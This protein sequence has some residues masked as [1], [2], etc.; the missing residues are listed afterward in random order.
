MKSI[1][2]TD[3]ALAVATIS[4]QPSPPKNDDAVQSHVYIL[5]CQGRSSHLPST[6]TSAS[7]VWLN[8]DDRQRRIASLQAS[9]PLLD[10]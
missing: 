1:D 10:S 9:G 7:K 8:K 4:S 6:P 2:G 5:F 3:L